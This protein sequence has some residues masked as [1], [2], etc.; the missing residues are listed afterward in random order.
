[1][2]EML[3]S[4][5]KKLE[6]K[7]TITNLFH[8]TIY[9]TLKNI[10]SP[11]SS[12]CGKEFQKEFEFLA[13]MVNKILTTKKEE[14]KSKQQIFSHLVLKDDIQTLETW[15]LDLLLTIG[16]EFD[17]EEVNFRAPTSAN[18]RFLTWAS[19]ANGAN[20]TDGASAA[21]TTDTASAA[22]ESRRKK[23]GWNPVAILGNLGN[24]ETKRVNDPDILTR[25][26]KIAELIFGQINAGNNK[27]PLDQ[28]FDGKI[29]LPTHRHILV[30]FLERGQF[31]Y[32]LE[33]FRNNEVKNLLRNYIERYY[34]VD[35]IH[36]AH[37]LDERRRIGTMLQDLLSK[38]GC[39]KD[40]RVAGVS[41]IT[42]RL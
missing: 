18:L 24:I 14:E 36:F 28:F 3:A 37:G 5:E 20:I 12:K 2:E 19:A 26:E 15:K 33:K 31:L 42:C 40:V 1:M 38:H 22:G 6:I 34:A 4:T 23:L 9:F 32:P 30:W 35:T 41:R 11:L 25:I 10:D 27:F 13:N 39:D 21:N 8:Q 7:I 16:F 29:L 17:Q